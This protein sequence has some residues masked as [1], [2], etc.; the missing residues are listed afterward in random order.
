V[1]LESVN[2]SLITL[3]L[4]NLNPKT[5]SDFRP[6]SLLNS[7]LKIITKILA[8]RLQQVI[9]QLIHKNQYG[10]I[11]SRTIHDCL[12]WC[13]EY[14]HQC[15][16]SRRQPIILKLDFEKTFDTVEHSA[17]IQILEHMGFLPRWVQWINNILSLGMFVVILNGVPGRKFKC[18]RGVCQ[19]DPLSPLIFV[20]A[21]ELLQILVNRA[22]TQ[23]LL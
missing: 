7:S 16:H 14:I 15:K 8:D 23:G 21:A 22:A 18:K 11:K 6:I 17:I 2:D 5:V 13:F 4:K 10:F 19:G 1:H 9:L 20:L 12:A 3:V